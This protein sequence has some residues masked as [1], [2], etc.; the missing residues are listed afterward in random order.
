MANYTYETKP[1][2]PVKLDLL[3]AEFAEVGLNVELV[4][5][6]YSPPMGLLRVYFYYDPP[7]V[8][9]AAV[10]TVIAGHDASLPSPMEMKHGQ[11]RQE[12]TEARAQLIAS[13]LADKTPAQVDAWADN[14]ANSM[15]DLASAR[16]AVRTLAKVVGK[17]LV[18]LAILVDE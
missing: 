17:A 9:I 3:Q 10:E 16:E 15:I 4:K 1:T 13:D 14:L 7:P 8:D 5:S 11:R 6:A 18:A 12:V 2:K